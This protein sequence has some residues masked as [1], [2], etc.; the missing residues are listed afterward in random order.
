MK[1]DELVKNLPAQA[2]ALWAKTP[3]KWGFGRSADTDD[4]DLWLPLYMHMADCAEVAKR[5]W[6]TWIPDGVKESIHGDEGFARRLFVFL[7]AAHDLGKATPEFQWKSKSLAACGRLFIPHMSNPNKIRHGLAGHRIL[8]RHAFDESVAVVLGGHHGKPPSCRD[9]LEIDS[10]AANTGFESTEWLDAQDALFEYVCALS[11]A[12]AE[13]LRQTVLAP[14]AQA[15]LTGLVIMTDWIASDES[16]FAY[17]PLLQFRPQ[18]SVQRAASAWDDLRLSARRE[19]RMPL[20]DADAYFRA[21]FGVESPRPIQTAV[22]RALSEA[23]NPGI[24]V[25][26][27]PMGEG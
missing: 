3:N 9:L 1:T 4:A 18:A 12:S 10:Y 21:R 20:R 15:L 23:K 22:F 11:G 17:I 26:E 13:E 5:L 7:A 8:T 2:K 6:E 14:H 19:T 25:I 16:R 27:A 24:V